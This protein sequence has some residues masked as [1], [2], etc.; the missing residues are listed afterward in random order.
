MTKA[1]TCT[2]KRRSNNPHQAVFEA[3]HQAAL[4][5]VAVHSCPYSHPPFVATWLRGFNAGKQLILPL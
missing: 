1:T 4:D 2:D 3:G 5:G